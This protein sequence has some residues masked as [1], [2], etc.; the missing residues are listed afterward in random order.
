[1]DRI[2]DIAIQYWTTWVFGLISAGIIFYIKGIKKRQKQ[3]EARQNAIEMGLQALLRGELVRAYD[4]YSDRD[5]ITLHGLDACEKVYAAYHSL[6]GNGSITT[7]MERMREL[8][9]KD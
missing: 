5:S 2:L 9:V 7:L 4:K 8:E 3:Q 1:M 6:G